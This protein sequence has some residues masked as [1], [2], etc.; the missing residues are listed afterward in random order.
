MFYRNF[1]K[2]F[3]IKGRQTYSRKKKPKNEPSRFKNNLR[4]QIELKWN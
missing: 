1:T 3:Y 4:N 2:T